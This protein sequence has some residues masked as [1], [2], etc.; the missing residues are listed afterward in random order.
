MYA[1]RN[2]VAHANAL[3]EGQ[4]GHL[5]MGQMNGKSAAFR[6]K[7][8]VLYGEAPIILL[9][10]RSALDLQSLVLKKKTKNK[11]RLLFFGAKRPLKKNG[12]VSG[13]LDVLTAFRLSTNDLDAR[14]VG[15]CM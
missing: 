5:T 8:S 6:L 9:G 4:D 13:T 7:R 10:P 2:L 15:I 3:G 14:L 12:F 1:L 11:K